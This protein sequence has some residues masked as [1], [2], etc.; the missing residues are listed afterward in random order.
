GIHGGSVVSEGALSEILQDN[1]FLTGA[2]I[3][4]LRKVPLP[5]KRRIADGKFIQINNASENNLKD[6]TVKIPL[7]MLV[8]IT[9]VSGSGKSSLINE[10]LVKKLLATLRD[11][12]ITPGKHES[13]IGLEHISDIRNIDQS[14]IG[15]SKRS[16]PATFIGIY[17][18][19]RDLYADLP[20]AKL[21]NLDK[22]HFS[23]NNKQ[24][25]CPECAGLGVIKTNFQFMAD[26]EFTCPICHGNR[27]AKMVLEIMYKEKHVGQVFDMTVEEA[28][29]FFE[30][31]NLIHHKLSVME[32]VGLGYLKLGQSTT[33]LSGGEA[34]RLKIA[35]ELAKIKEEKNN[36]Y[37]LDEPTTGLHLEDASKLLTCLN[38]LID[39]R[40]TV[41][42]IEHNLEVIKAADYIIDLGPEGG[43][44]G[45]Y[46]VAL[47]TP[48]D[49]AQSTKS[50]TGQYL[51]EVLIKSTNEVI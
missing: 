14:P 20:K 49:L 15:Y 48:E 40:N 42:I 35:R 13:V 24:G 21:N 9:G 34:Q 3:N 44:S 5:R 31:I 41:I 29:S 46:I 16:N 43:K 50:F 38:Q 30:E 10:I 32:E 28:R 45:G 39:A 33:T 27:Y 47:G 19:I 8:C 36:L 25:R 37:V 4:G 23:F 12:R 51:K 11:P 6:I 7:H 2:Y 17:D 22:S 26:V 1:N 18:K